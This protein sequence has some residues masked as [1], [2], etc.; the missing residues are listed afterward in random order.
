MRLDAIL[1][2]P[3]KYFRPRRMHRFINEFAVSDTTHIL[4]VGGEPAF[5]ADFPF[6][7]NLTLVNT[8]RL[9]TWLN[10]CA[11][12]IA[13]GCALPFRQTAFDI[14][15][16][17]S[18]IEHLG[19][20]QAQQVFADEIRRVARSLW[21]QTPARWFPIESHLAGPFIHYLPKRV[22]RKV[23]RWLTLW[24]WFA[25]DYD[26]DIDIFLNEVRLLTY[27]EMRTLFPDCEIHKERW[28]FLTKAYIAV[29]KPSE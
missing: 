26:R 8:H 28:L 5:W 22:Q 18:V 15:F 9:P 23:A 7:A 6:K 21:V 10:D 29:R 2:V 11:L 19:T 4:D 13:D 27:K 14:G 3:S 20:F 24:G 25:T 16:S 12:L 17:N 1:F